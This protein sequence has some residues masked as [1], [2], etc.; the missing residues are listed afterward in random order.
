MFLDIMNNLTLYENKKVKIRF[1]YVYIEKQSKTKALVLT[2][3]GT[4]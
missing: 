3:L 1:H 2:D 4:I